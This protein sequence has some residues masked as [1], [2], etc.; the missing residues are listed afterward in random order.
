MWTVSGRRAVSFSCRAARRFCCRI[1]TCRWEPPGR[2]SFPIGLVCQVCNLCIWTFN[3]TVTSQIFAANDL[4]LNCFKF[5][6]WRTAGNARSNRQDYT[7]ANGHPGHHSDGLIQGFSPQKYGCLFWLNFH[8]KSRT[9]EIWQFQSAFPR[10]CCL[11]GL[12]RRGHLRCS[13]QPRELPG[14]RYSGCGKSTDS[15]GGWE[16]HGSIALEARPP[17]ELKFHGS[18]AFHRYK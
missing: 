3:L 6:V 7:S 4:N 15:S 9:F 17:H 14:D 18:I 5:A 10:S 12:C 1:W 8:P 16:N 11:N 13:L 2:L